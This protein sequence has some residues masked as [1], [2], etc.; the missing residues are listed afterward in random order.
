[1][2]LN[3]FRIFGNLLNEILLRTAGTF[4]GAPQDPP[5]EEEADDQS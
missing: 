3:P 5:W 2:T 4:F 1:M